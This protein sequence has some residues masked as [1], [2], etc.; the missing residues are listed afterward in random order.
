[1]AK[2]ASTLEF[3]NTAVVSRVFGRC[4]LTP[5]DLPCSEG[6]GNPVI[7]A[8]LGQFVLPLLTNVVDRCGK[9]TDTVAQKAVA[10]GE[11]PK[12]SAKRLRQA[13]LDGAREYC[14]NSGKKFVRREWLMEMATAQT[15][16][17]AGIHELSAQ[18]EDYVK[19]LSTAGEAI[20]VRL[21]LS[22]T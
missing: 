8:I 2:K 16:A 6:V 10:A 14:A 21:D 15:L 12:T 3:Q 1:M 22:T 17:V 5:D 19:R 13:Y 11:T 7:F 4:D 18:P 20:S 9:K